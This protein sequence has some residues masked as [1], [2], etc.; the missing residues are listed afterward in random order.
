M[1][2]TVARSRQ[3]KRLDPVSTCHES[4]SHNSKFYTTILYFQDGMTNQNKI[5]NQFKI[6]LPK[7]GH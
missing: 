5:Q 1:M 6:Q 7:K 2:L 4:K 3:A